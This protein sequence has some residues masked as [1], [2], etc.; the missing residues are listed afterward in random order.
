[1]L[2]MLVLRLHPKTTE[3]EVLK[4]GPAICFNQNLLAI[5]MQT[6]YIAIDTCI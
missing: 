3:A 4:V 5:L 6:G 1:M 2:E